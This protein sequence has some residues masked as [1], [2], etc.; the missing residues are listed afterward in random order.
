MRT[1]K[2]CLAWVWW[3]VCL[4]ACDWGMSYTHTILCNAVLTYSSILH[5]ACERYNIW[6]LVAICSGWK[7][8]FSLSSTT[9]EEDVRAK[10]AYFFRIIYLVATIEGECSMQAGPGPIYDV[11]G[12]LGGQISSKNTTFPAF[13]VCSQCI[14]CHV[15]ICLRGTV[16]SVTIVLLVC[17]ETRTRISPNRNIL[18]NEHWSPVFDGALWCKSL[19]NEMITSID[20][21]DIFGNGVPASLAQYSAPRG[22]WTTSTGVPW[23][24]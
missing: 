14:Y 18:S 4:L 2:A 21:D 23:S 13:K 5:G 11:P 19:L 3:Y 20:N 16:N 6:G 10:Y 7:P 24:R 22:V 1:D 15:Y 17:A 8:S 9:L 12:A